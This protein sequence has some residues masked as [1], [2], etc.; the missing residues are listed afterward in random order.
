MPDV[1]QVDTAAILANDE[2]GAC[3]TRWSMRAFV[4]K[5]LQPVERYGTQAQEF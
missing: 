3:L 2:F 1:S 5:R 4:Y